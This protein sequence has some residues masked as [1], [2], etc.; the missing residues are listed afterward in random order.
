MKFYIK[1]K[2]YEI[3]LIET[4]NTFNLIFVNPITQIDYYQ[5]TFCIH[6]DILNP[7]S[8]YAISHFNTGCLC[9]ITTNKI[10]FSKI[11]SIT[12][13]HCA[14]MIKL[15]GFDYFLNC[16]QN[17]SKINFTLIELLTNY[18]FI[19]LIETSNSSSSKLLNIKRRILRVLD[20]GIL[21][22]TRTREF[23]IPWVDDDVILRLATKK[24]KLSN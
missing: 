23:I 12:Y 15:N 3:K 24:Y 17:K 6:N 7:N 2:N 1:L 18:K 9:L 22:S 13:N 11:K 14:N 20:S 10:E 8:D 16:L 4:I 19:T 5:E 21:T